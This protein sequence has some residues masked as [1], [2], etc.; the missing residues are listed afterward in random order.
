M[1]GN[2][3]PHLQVRSIPH[4]KWGYNNNMNDA[5]LL[6][7]DETI[8]TIKPIGLAQADQVRSRMHCSRPRCGH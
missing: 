1:N 2:I 7:F 3:F 5:A 4:P 6:V 8:T